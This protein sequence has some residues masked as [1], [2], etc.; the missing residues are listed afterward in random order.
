MSSPS[1]TASSTLLTSV[2]Q[3]DEDAWQRLAAVYGPLVYGWA[4]QAGV[5][6]NDAA[7]VVQEVFVSVM[8]SIDRF[9]RDRPGDSFRAWLRTIS[10]NRLT[11]YFRR[12][13]SQPQGTGDTSATL[14]LHEVSETLFAD[15]GESVRDEIARIRFRALLALKGSFQD[16]VWQAF[17]QTVVLEKA[18]AEV[19]IELETSKWAVYKAKARV[20]KRLRQELAEL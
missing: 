18:P 2:R 17:W 6:E 14:Q 1:Q 4:R 20:L 12:L 9:R 11:D 19:A 13:R 5:Q 7:D 16:Q 15:E 10:R 8:R 3:G